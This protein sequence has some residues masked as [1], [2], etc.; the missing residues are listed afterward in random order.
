MQDRINLDNNNLFFLSVFYDEKGNVRLYSIDIEKAN[1][2]HY[3]LEPREFKK[4]EKV[5]QKNCKQKNVVDNLRTL[6]LEGK[7]ELES[8]FKVYDIMRDNDIKFAIFSY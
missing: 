2:C 8:Q 4:L 1:D 6:I 3:E 5:L 7:S